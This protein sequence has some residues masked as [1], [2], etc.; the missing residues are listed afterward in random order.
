[1]KK[2]HLLNRMIQIKIGKVVDKFTKQLID[3]MISVIILGYV[4]PVPYF[5]IFF[6]FLYFCL[7]A[8]IS[9]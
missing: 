4:M 1:M 3:R 9:E 7:V 5:L 2:K 6:L 8:C